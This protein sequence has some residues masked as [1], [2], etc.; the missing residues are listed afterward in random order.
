MTTFD[1]Y[2][3]D[4]LRAKIAS[5]DYSAELMLHHAMLNIETLEAE[6]HA[7]RAR[8]Q[9]YIYR[10]QDECVTLRKEMNP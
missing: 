1:L 8:F 9:Q 7:W 2:T 6:V 4:E 5:H 3:T 10:P